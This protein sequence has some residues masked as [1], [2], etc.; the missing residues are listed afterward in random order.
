MGYIEHYQKL[1]G[2]EC[3]WKVA[4]VEL[5]GRDCRVDVWVSIQAGWQ[6][7]CPECGR[8]LLL[9]DQFDSLT[10]RRQEGARPAIY[11]HARVPRV[12]CWHHGIKEIQAPWKTPWSGFSLVPDDNADQPAF[13]DDTLPHPML[14]VRPIEFVGAK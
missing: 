5:S 10:W 3:P 13:S 7:P 8:L 11:L 6:L 1:I 4:R 12:L 14:V 2:L 9:H